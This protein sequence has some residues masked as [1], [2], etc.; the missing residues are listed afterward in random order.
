MGEVNCAL[1]DSPA[2]TSNARAQ[3]PGRT[4][5]GIA[6][7]DGAF[8]DYTTLP[9]ANLHGIPDHVSN[10]VAIFICGSVPIKIISR[11]YLG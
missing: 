5:L 10:N 2:R 11:W 3:S 7:R 6:G 4:R 1:C 9:I 8:A